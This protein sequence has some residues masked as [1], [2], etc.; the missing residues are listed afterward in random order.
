[1]DFWYILCFSSLILINLCDVPCPSSH[2]T[3]APFSLHQTFPW[4]I[5]PSNLSSERHRVQWLCGQVSLSNFHSSLTTRGSVR[6]L[7]MYGKVSRRK[8][9][10]SRRS[11]QAA[12][13]S[14]K[15]QQ[16]LVGFTVPRKKN[17][18]MV[19]KKIMQNLEPRGDGYFHVWCTIQAA[20]KK[21]E[22]PD[23]YLCYYSYT[24]RVIVI[25]YWSMYLPAHATVPAWYSVL[26]YLLQYI[27]RNL[28]N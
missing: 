25:Q 4:V 6:G 21:E 13:F 19:S 12:I 2:Q 7:G 28:L 27:V 1:M 11:W 18:S 15:G 8:V 24:K 22:N 26:S 17:N 9:V 10:I 20:L 16:H 14:A 23:F 3:K 5:T